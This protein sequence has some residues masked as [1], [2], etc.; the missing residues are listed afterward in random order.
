MYPQLNKYYLN[1]KF[2]LLSINTY[3]QKY[4]NFCSCFLLWSIW[5]LTGDHYI[6]EYF[7]KETR[8]YTENSR[9]DLIRQN[10]G[11]CKNTVNKTSKL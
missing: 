7:E 10:L 4:V 1:S 9:Q 6:L 2:Q 5:T 11:I 8:D 3:V